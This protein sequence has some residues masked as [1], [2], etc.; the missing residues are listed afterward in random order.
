MEFNVGRFLLVEM[1]SASEESESEVLD[2]G[3][4]MIVF[5][6]EVVDCGLADANVGFESTD[7]R[8][9]TCDQRRRS[10]F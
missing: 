9:R 4:M 10:R 5:R 7:N 1:D 8:F 2:R 6:R 3:F